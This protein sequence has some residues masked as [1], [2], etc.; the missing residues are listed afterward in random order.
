MTLLKGTS[1]RKE[2]EAEFVANTVL[3]FEIRPTQEQEKQLFYLF[4]L[5]RKLY[6]F[7]IEERIQHYKETGRGL[8]YLEQQSRL[9]AFKEANPEYT[10]VPAQVL[11][12]VLRRVDRAFVNFFEKRASYPR[13][14]DKLRY[15][16]MTLPQSETKRNFGQRGQIYFPKI[17]QIKL[18]AHQPFNP[19]EVKIINIKY[20]GGKW[21]ANLTVETT[22]EPPVSSRERVV[23][24]D[25]GLNHLAFTSDG[26]SYEN[27]RW[28]QQSEKCLKK[29][30][31]KLS[32]KNKGSRNREKAKRQMQQKHDRIT[33]Q[34]KD[35]L[36]KLSYEL[37]NKYDVICIEDLRVK[38]MMKNH[39]L[40]KSIANASWNRLSNYLSY[41]S[42]RYGKIF[43]KV[44]P[45][46]TSQQCSGCG[47]IAK[48]KKTLSE[49]IHDCPSCLIVLDRDHNAA[50][51]IREAGLRM[52]S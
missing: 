6:N 19:S 38:E 36:H 9:P 35:Y 49:R 44:D 37:I 16:S 10:S 45:K 15:R 47:Y 14:K 42:K 24:I 34:R 8:T 7:A 18:N 48:A 33:N 13:F 50:I 32:K 17:G 4:Y 29:V 5:C 40:A 26:M 43:I 41:K 23:G 51:N 28:I 46:Y 1:K 30:Q 31:R 27:P 20:Q 52:L 3:R 39:R 21:F 22:C 2:S 11:Q 25:M 12:D